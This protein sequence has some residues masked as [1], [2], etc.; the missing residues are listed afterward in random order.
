M[1]NNY[2]QIPIITLEEAVEPLVLYVPEVNDMVKLVKQKCQQP[3]DNLS[4]DESASIMLFTMRW[5]PKQNSFRYI[6][7]QKLKSNNSNELYPWHLYLKLICISLSKL[8]TLSYQ[9]FY[10]EVQM[11][12]INEYSLDTKFVSDGFLSCQ[13]S[14]EAVDRTDISTLFIILSNQG[15]N[16]S[17]HTYDI[18]EN[19]ILLPDGQQFQVVSNVKSQDGRRI[20]I[21]RELPF[22]DSDELFS[23]PQLQ[24]ITD[25]SFDLLFQQRIIKNESCLEINLRNQIL[26]DHHINK[27]VEEGIKNNQCTWLTLQNSYITLNGLFIL[28]DGLKMNK[29]LEA[30]YL[31]RNLVN[32]ISVKLLTDIALCKYTNLTMLA[33]DH[34]QIRNEGAQYLANMLKTNETLTD[35]WLSYNKIGDQGVQYFADV[36]ASKNR[37]LMQLYLN[38]NKLISDLNVDSLVYALKF[39]ATLNTLWL[40]DCNLSQESKQNLENSV[41]HKHDFYLNV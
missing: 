17:Q 26:M 3:K 38:G 1:M 33:L 36:L 23:R 29:S 28:A 8:P 31:S 6:C 2:E 27:I 21:L 18:T 12:L 24:D 22:N 14:I 13:L 10:C 30:L 32:D 9:I 35:L 5:V 41:E 20:I 37:T 16:I 4:I 40:Q 7:N 39:N 34:N 15:K 11:D 19:E 25:R